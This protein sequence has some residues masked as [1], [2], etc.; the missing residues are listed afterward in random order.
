M[1]LSFQDGKKLP[2]APAR[3]GL[4]GSVAR[5]PIKTSL[6][7]AGPQGRRSV[8]LLEQVLFLSELP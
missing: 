1:T 8:E 5:V 7:E 2:T 4:E 6:A 3:S